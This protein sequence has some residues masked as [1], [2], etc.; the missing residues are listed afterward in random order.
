M[1]DKQ[2]IDDI[3]L[4]IGISKDDGAQDELITLAISESNEYSET[5]ITK[6][7]DRLR[8]I[9]RD[10]AIKRFNRINSEGTVEDSE[11]GK[12]FKWDSYLKE[13][14][15]T[16]RSAAIGKVYSGKGVARFI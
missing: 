15:S 11:E 1:G 8:F 10:V 2:L 5:E 12:T 16:L 13:Y 14:E 9:V 7:P 3:K 6:I 4:F